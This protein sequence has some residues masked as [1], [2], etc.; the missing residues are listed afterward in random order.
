MSDILMIPAPDYCTAQR[1]NLW[2]TMTIGPRAPLLGIALRDVCKASPVNPW[3]LGCIAIELSDSFASTDAIERNDFF[4]VGGEFASMDEAC[5]YALQDAMKS[6]GLDGYPRLKPEAV[7]SVRG[8]YA[9]YVR[10]AKR[11]S[12][13]RDEPKPTPA[14]EPKPEPVPAPAPAPAPVPVPEPVKPPAA[15]TPKWKSTV[16]IVIGVLTAVLGM[17]AW[18]IPDHLEMPLRALLAALKALVGS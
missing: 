8:L 5:V 13:E 12:G 3:V 16:K 2:M 10:F 18:L 9:Q 4:A 1:F 17:A 6:N 11:M 15:S 14:P 7:A